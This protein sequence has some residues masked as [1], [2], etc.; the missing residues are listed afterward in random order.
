VNP[1]IIKTTH[2]LANRPALRLPAGQAG[3]NGG[4]KVSAKRLGA[5][6]FFQGL[7]MGL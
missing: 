5:N 7:S 4:F 1:K 6:E 2:E 3:N